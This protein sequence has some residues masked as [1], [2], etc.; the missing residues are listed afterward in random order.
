MPNAF[1]ALSNVG[2][3]PQ[4]THNIVFID[5]SP[6]AALRMAAGWLRL[7]KEDRLLGFAC[8][9]VWSSAP[10]S[11]SLPCTVD[12]MMSVGADVRKLEATDMEELDADDFDTIVML[13]E[14]DSEEM[15]LDEDW[16][17]REIVLEWQ[18]PRSCAPDELRDTLREKVTELLEHF[19]VLKMKRA[20]GQGT[21]C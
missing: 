11:L 4:Y 10:Y 15:V 20:C 8:A 5:R 16:K 17:E 21:S 12:A 7:L 1:G 13:R 14:E 6:G 19:D 9:E 2:Y 18:F 3:G